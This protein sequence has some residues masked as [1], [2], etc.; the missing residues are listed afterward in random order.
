MTPEQD[1]TVISDFFNI[2]EKY[3]Y[4]QMKTDQDWENFGFEVRDCAIK[5]NW[6]TNPLAMRLAFCVLDVLSDLYRDGKVPP[7]PDYFGRSDL[8]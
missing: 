3:R 5:H 4:T 1:R 7:I 6:M 8:S 2:Y